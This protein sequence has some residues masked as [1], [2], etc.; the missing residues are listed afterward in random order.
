MQMKFISKE[1]VSNRQGKIKAVAVVEVTFDD[2]SEPISH[3]QTFTFSVRPSAPQRRIIR[4]LTA[5]AEAE[6]TSYFNG[7]DTEWPNMFADWEKEPEHT[8]LSLSDELELQHELREI[9]K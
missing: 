9:E 8:S 2:A 6:I 5:R 7:E 4:K 3:K 1:I